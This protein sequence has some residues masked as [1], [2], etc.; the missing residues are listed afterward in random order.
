MHI[1]VEPIFNPSRAYLAD[2]TAFGFWCTLAAHG[3]MAT[4]RELDVHHIVTHEAQLI[5]ATTSYSTPHTHKHKH[6]HRESHSVSV[7]CRAISVSKKENGDY[8]C[9]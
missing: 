1:V 6:K 7:C 9:R 5:T 4:R 8:V 3:G 2:W